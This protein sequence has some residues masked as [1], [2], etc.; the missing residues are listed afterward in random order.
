V[1]SVNS[2]KVI[3][4]PYYF[5]QGTYALEVKHS[6]GKV[7]RYGE[8]TGKKPTGVTLNSA[9]TAGQ[10][11]V[12]VGKVNSGCCTPM[13]HFEMYAGTATGALTTSGNKFNRRSDLMDPTT[14][15]STWE[16]AKFG[17]SY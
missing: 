15:L 1:V 8:I 3:R 9:L 12:Y 6:D 16:K 10:V 2:G 4:A 7:V 13:L 17:V 11:V 14:Y 5:Y